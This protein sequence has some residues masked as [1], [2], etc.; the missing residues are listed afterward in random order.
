VDFNPFFL[1]F[2]EKYLDHREISLFVVGLM[3][4]L[5]DPVE[6]GGWMWDMVRDADE[7]KQVLMQVA[8]NDNQVTTLGAHYQAR[9]YGAKTIAPAT[10]SIWG[11]EE[12]EG[13]WDGSALVEFRYEDLPDEPAAAVPPFGP[14][15]HECPRRELAGQ[16][17]LGEFLATGLVR[18]YCDG[19]CTSISTDVC[20]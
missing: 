2:K 13:P 19:T 14:D 5:W 9:A 12:A 6:P 3:Q 18:N 16:L 4:Q 7:P 1:T 8:I 11:I 17:Q 15:P 10:R 20:R